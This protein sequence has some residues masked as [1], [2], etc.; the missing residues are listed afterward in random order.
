MACGGFDGAFA[1]SLW[2]GKPCL[3]DLVVI[4]A[5]FKVA[6]VWSLRK[7]LLGLGLGNPVSGAEPHL[8]DLKHW[9]LVKRKQLRIWMALWGLVVVHGGFD[10]AF[11]WLENS[12]CMILWSLIQASRALGLEAFGV[13]FGAWFGEPRFREL[14][15]TCYWHLLKREQLRIWMVFWWSR[16]FGGALALLPCI[17]AD[18][19]RCL[20]SIF[21]GYG[22]GPAVGRVSSTKAL[23]NE[24]GSS[25]RHSQGVLDGQLPWT[26]VWANF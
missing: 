9:H 19:Q 26:W 12:V 24:Q 8:V 7:T 10:G 14:N 3:D 11:A 17:S 6:L 23:R 16:A 22:F 13:G 18:A 25:E 21:H 2:A 20:P 4:N 5:C 15:P 1:W